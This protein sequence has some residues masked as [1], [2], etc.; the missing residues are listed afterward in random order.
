MSP[1]EMEATCN[2]SLDTAR[3]FGW[4]E[5]DACVTLVTPKGF[6]PPPGFP[7]GNLLQ[8]KEDGHRLSSYP[9]LRL[10]A[11]IRKAVAA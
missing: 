6:R 10:L 3:K 5:K 9:A 11:W 7:R 8:V 2:A 4:P 1:T